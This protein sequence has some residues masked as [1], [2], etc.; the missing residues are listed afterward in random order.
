MNLGLQL[1]DEL[2]SLLRE[3]VE[4]SPELT[5]LDTFGGVAKSALSPTACLDEVV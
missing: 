4:Q 5:V 2:R 1:R 3:D